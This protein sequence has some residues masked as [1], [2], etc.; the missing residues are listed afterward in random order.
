MTTTTMEE[1]RTEPAVPGDKMEGLSLLTDL[2][3]LTMAQGYWKSGRANTQAVFHVFYRTQPFN[4]GYAICAGLEPAIQWL[5]AL[6]FTKSDTDYLAT[7]KGNDGKPLFDPAFLEY[8]LNMGPLSLD[9]DAVPEGTV[10]FPF[11]PLVRVKGPI[12]QA[13]LVETALLCMINFG[14]LVATKSARICASCLGEPVLEFGFRRAQGLDGALTASRAAYIGGC[15]ATSNVLAGKRYGI[16][17]AGTH[18]HSWVQSFPSQQ[19]AFDQWAATA[20]NNCVLLVDTYDTLTGVREAIKTAKKLVEKGYKFAGIRLDSGDLAWLSIEAKKLLVAAG[21]PDAKIFASND[22]DEHLVTTLKHQ[23]AAINMWGIGTK[24]VTCNDQPA[25]GGVYKLAATM[26]E[27][28]TTWKPCIKLSEMAI[29]VSNPGVLN[30]RRWIVDGLFAGDVIWDECFKPEKSWRAVDPG[31]A[32]RTKDMPE[33]NGTTVIAE[34]MLVPIF[35]KG[36]LV[37]TP[38]PLSEVRARTLKQLE[39]LSPSNKRL[40]NPHTYIV[41][42]EDSLHKRKTDLIIRERE[43][44]RKLRAAAEKPADK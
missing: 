43:V 38:P 35:V 25:L 14:T 10:V 13:Q 18:A 21:F 22:L 26:E 33:P 32:T 29:K 11:E 3:Q 36:K 40:I 27:G 23:G 30:T 1:F 28:E 42:L 2:Y 17:V 6:R 34:D 8:L 7:L 16:P 37:Y 9:V 15:A 31:D 39:M 19:E 24:L 44:V 4:G 20:P 41:G 12:L 5:H